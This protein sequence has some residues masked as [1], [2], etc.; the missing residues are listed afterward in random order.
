M[1]EDRSIT[2]TRVIQ[3]PA[4]VVWKCWT[5]PAILPQWFGPKGHSC[6]TKSIDLR[7]GGSWRFD[8]LGPKGEVWANRHEFTLYDPPKRIEF[9][10]SD[11][12]DGDP[13]AWVTVTLEPEGQGTRVT[14]VVVFPDAAI[15]QAVVDF[16]AIE[17]GQTT[18]DKL[19]AMAEGFA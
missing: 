3:A 7:Q 10:M 4:E 15:R 1:S 12:S 2:L 11:D 9:V 16:G 18:L 17:L 5:D 14:Q 6:Q 13:H 8:M 19:A